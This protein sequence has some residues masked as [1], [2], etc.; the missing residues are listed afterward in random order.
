MDLN[1][2]AGVGHEVGHVG[3]T[4]LS[5]QHRIRSLRQ[6]VVGRPDDERTAQRV[7]RPRVQ[8]PRRTAGSKD[9]TGLRMRNFWSDGG[10]LQFGEPP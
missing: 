5:Q 1:D 7:D 8:D 9:V 6:D 2:A 4:S 3:D 10:R